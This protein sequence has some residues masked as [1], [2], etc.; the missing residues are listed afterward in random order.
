ML[1]RAVV[2]AAF[3]G[4]GS[5]AWAQTPLPQAFETASIKPSKDSDRPHFGFSAG[6][7]FT[8]TN[9]T[10]KYLVQWAWNL[11]AYQIIG[12]PSWLDS[13]QYDIIAIPE[14]AVG[15]K[16]ETIEVARQMMRKLLADRLQLRVN[17]ET[18]DLPRYALVRSRNGTD[19]K[20]VER[21][22]DATDTFVR[23]TP[24]HLVGQKVNM[25]I[26]IPILSEVTGREVIDQ[27]GNTG[28]FDFKLDWSTDENPQAD[29]SIFTAVQEQLG[30]RLV[31][32]RGPVEVLVIGNAEMPSNN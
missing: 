15:P 11:R 6:G 23:G 29:P 1:A 10:V 31:S 22:T 3:V 5:I 24:G 19:M 20:A 18:K 8:A 4:P 21:S 28:F 25:S 9:V 27:T 26:L 7:R 2:V 14:Q 12:G 13:A 32:E 16:L 30:F 17:R